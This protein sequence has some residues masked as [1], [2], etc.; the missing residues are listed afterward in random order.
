MQNQAITRQDIENL[1][2]E[3]IFS[4]IDDLQDQNRK[5]VDTTSWYESILDAIPFPMSVTDMNMNWTFINQ[6]TEKM[7]NRMTTDSKRTSTVEQGKP[8]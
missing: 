7:L 1:S 6:A 4:I 2:R 3:E 8:V 5:L